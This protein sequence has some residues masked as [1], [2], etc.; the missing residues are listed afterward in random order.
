[1]DWSRYACFVCTITLSKFYFSGVGAM[2]LVAMDMKV[3]Y[4][5]LVLHAS[6]CRLYIDVFLAPWHVYGASVEF[7]RSNV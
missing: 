4:V 5:Y 6:F 7:C 3:R 1:M 2:E